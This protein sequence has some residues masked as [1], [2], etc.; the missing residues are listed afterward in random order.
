M[1]ARPAASSA[2]REIRRSLMTVQRLEHVGVV[3]D[4][5]EGRGPSSS[6]S[7]EKVA[8]GCPVRL[9]P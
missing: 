2:A 3:V 1:E 9:G 4:D 5:L 8:D 7:A 6:H